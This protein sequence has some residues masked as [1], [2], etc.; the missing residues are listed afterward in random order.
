MIIAEFEVKPEGLE[1]VPRACHRG[2]QPVGRQGARLPSVR[3]HGRSGPASRVVLYEVY[4]DEAAFDAHLQDARISQTFRDGIEPLVV[5]PQRAPPDPRA[6]LRSA[7]DE[8]GSWSRSRACTRRRTRASSACAPAGCE[9]VV[10]PARPDASTEDELAAML[11]GVLRDHRGRRA[12]HRAG[13]RRGAAA[14][15]WSRAWASAT[16]RSTSP[17][18]RR[19]GVAVAMGF[20]TNH[21]AV[22][23]MAFTLMA[24]LGNRLFAYHQEVMDG[25]LGRAFPPAARG[26]RPSGILGLGRI[27]RALAR[28]C[29]GFEMRVLAYDPVADPA[30]AAAAR[31][32]AGRA[33][34][35]VPRRRISSRSTRRTPPRPTSSSAARAWR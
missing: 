6:R 2:C 10:Q 5:E 29:R 3:R 25:P 19:H 15:G 27:G 34:R 1:R 30:Y 31:H 9:L 11:P 20:G 22:A 14:A 13:V 17:P 32:R 28:R 33:R 35:A 12:L 23:D 26:A 21:E 24:A 16:T 18:R 4:D 7:R 8:P